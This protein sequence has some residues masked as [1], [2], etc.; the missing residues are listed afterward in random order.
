MFRKGFN[1]M[2]KSKKSTK[3]QTK[4]QKKQK[5]EKEKKPKKRW[6]TWFG[7][8]FRVVFIPTGLEIKTDHPVL[9]ELP[10]ADVIIV[11]KKTKNWTKAQ[12]KYMPDGIRHAKTPHVLIELKVTE[13]I[14]D[15]AFLQIGGYTRFY[16]NTES[17]AAEDL[18]S[19]FI[20][21]KSPSDDTLKKY[22]YRKTKFSGVY[23]SNSPVCCLFTLISLNDL[24]DAPHNILCKLFAS[25]TKEHLK[26]QEKVNEPGFLKKLPMEIVLLITQFVQ[27]LFDKKKG[28]KG[29]DY[30]KLSAKQ[31]N[32]LMTTWVE[33]VIDSFGV[34][35]L[36]KKK[37][38]NIYSTE[39]VLSNYSMKEIEAYMK[40][41][42][43]KK[44]A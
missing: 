17:V 8:L 31:K 21:A 44:S 34:E 9:K 12:L 28:E 18:R 4:E 38:F 13:S 42:K 30:L 37:I 29:M 14:D 36:P 40:K 20:Y 33:N 23:K 39:D 41:R 26:A 6:H 5:Q 35:C 15:D 11:R 16:K 32:N 25:K 22:G 3:K 1:L 10:E 43:K 7:R 24:S 27:A 19:F 2:T